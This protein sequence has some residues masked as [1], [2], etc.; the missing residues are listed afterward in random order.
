PRVCKTYSISTMANSHA[1]R[2]AVCGCILAPRLSSSASTVP[3]P[4]AVLLD[5]N[6]P[7]R[8]GFE[9]LEAFQILSRSHPVLVM[10]SSHRTEDRTRAAAL[11]ASGYFIKPADFDEYHRLRDVV[12]E[13][14]AGSVMTSPRVCG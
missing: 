7:L 6:L 2:C 9:V 4:A 5:L 8:D 14:L 10:T 3:C 11:G 1:L 12:L 13:F